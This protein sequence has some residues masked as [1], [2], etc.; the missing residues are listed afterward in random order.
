MPNAH[1]TS[2]RDDLRVIMEEKGDCTL[3]F[4][5]E[6]SESHRNV[7]AQLFEE[8]EIVLLKHTRKRYLFLL[9]LWRE[10]DLLDQIIHLW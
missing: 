5:E 2:R 7:I 10:I 4:E 8:T 6:T 3:C 9:M 1:P